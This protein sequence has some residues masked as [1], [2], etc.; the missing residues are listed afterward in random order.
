MDNDIIRIYYGASDT[1]IAFAEAK[2]EDLIQLC[3]KGE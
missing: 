2:E 3:L 1:V